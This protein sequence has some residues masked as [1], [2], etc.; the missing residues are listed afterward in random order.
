MLR[1]PRLFFQTFTF[2]KQLQMSFCRD[3]ERKKK[4][5]PGTDLRTTTANQETPQ[6]AATSRAK[7]FGMGD[8]LEGAGCSPAAQEPIVALHPHK[9]CTKGGQ[10]KKEKKETELLKTESLL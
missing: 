6:Q 2:L 10:Q 7:H 4:T 1:M 5:S 3:K 8:L 9:D